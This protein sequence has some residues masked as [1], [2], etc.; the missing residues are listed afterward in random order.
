MYFELNLHNV[1]EI[2]TSVQYRTNLL[3]ALGV[4]T[5][6]IIVPFLQILMAYIYFKKSHIWSRILNSNLS[7]RV[8]DGALEGNINLRTIMDLATKR[9][10]Y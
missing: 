2:L 3:L 9:I 6:G 5:F 7:D 8:L 1:T 10:M 4:I